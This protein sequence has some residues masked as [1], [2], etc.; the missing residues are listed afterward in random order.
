MTKP[1]VICTRKWP[2]RVEAELKRRFEVTLNETDEPMDAEA[3]RRAVRAHMRAHFDPVFVPRRI[4]FV[5][6]LP[7]DGTGKIA[8][9]DLAALCVPA[10]PRRPG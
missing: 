3:L 4:G 8:A 10:A 5:D 7:R 1:R 6:A 2:E 9:R